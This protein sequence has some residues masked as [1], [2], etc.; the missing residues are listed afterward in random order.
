MVITLNKSVTVMHYELDVG[1]H[2]KFVS[3][4]DDEGRIHRATIMTGAD[5]R[6]MGEPD[7]ITMTIEP[8]DRLN[9]KESQPRYE[10]P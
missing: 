7:V 5:W 6:A 1:E 9:R 2:A 4:D 8:G 3:R 10:V